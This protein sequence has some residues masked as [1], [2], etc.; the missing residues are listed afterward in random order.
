MISKEKLFAMNLLKK[1][2]EEFQKEKIIQIGIKIDLINND[3]FHWKITIIGPKDT[4]YEGGVF[5]II[6]NFKDDYPNS[7]PEVKFLNKIYNLHVIPRNGNILISQLF[8]WNSK[9]KIT[10]IIV[11]IFSIFY[12][13]NT[14]GHGPYDLLMAQEYITDREEFNRK[15]K[16]WT[17]KYAS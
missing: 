12:V 14:N 16:E 3:Y 1:E 2:Y 11:T 17:K 4:P 13:Q 10:D 15:A 7:K 8:S 5:S 9:Y 6:A